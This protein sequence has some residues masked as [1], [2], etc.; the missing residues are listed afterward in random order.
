MFFM[1]ISTFMRFLSQHIQ[2]KCLSIESHKNDDNFFRHKRINSCWIKLIS[3]DFLKECF[4]F[5]L[6]LVQHVENIGGTF[7]SS[8]LIG[9]SFWLKNELNLI[10]R[11]IEG[12]FKMIQQLSRAWIQKKSVLLE[13]FSINGYFQ[14]FFFERGSENKLTVII[15]QRR[16]REN[17]SYKSTDFRGVP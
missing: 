14:F 5:L 8:Q 10:L 1:L 13:I 4:F 9:N 2:K 7:L 17:G 3:E 15:L 11:H 12:M 16:E 6:P